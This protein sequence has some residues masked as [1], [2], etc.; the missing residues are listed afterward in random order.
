MAAIC[1]GRTV[2][3]IAHRLS[4]VRHADRIIVMDKGCV[5]E[6]GS[7]DDLLRQP[8]GLYAHLWSMQAGASGRQ[9]GAALDAAA[10]EP[11]FVPGHA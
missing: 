10:G 7:H 2:I 4:S 8:R 3:V 1:R 6:V 5:V 11:V 9:P